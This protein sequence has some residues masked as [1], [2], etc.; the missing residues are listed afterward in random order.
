[1]RQGLFASFLW[2]GETHA[3]GVQKRQGGL[4]CSK[5]LH[6]IGQHPSHIATPPANLPDC[7]ESPLFAAS[8]E[9]CKEAKNA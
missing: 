3:G 1:M 7:L 9:F 8:Q 2:I 4:S 5:G 6:A